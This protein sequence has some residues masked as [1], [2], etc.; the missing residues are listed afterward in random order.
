MTKLSDT[1][2]RNIIRRS[3]AAISQLQDGE[4]AIRVLSGIY[5]GSL[6]DKSPRQGELMAREVLTWISEFQDSYDRAAEDPENCLPCI[7]TIS[8]VTVFPKGLS[9]P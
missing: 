4:D 6:P 1:E 9:A 8:W 2:Q 7:C 5:C 3:A